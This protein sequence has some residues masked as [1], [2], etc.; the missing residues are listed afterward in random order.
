MIG[1][2]ENRQRDGGNEVR[3]QGGGGGGCAERESRGSLSSCSHF[4]GSVFNYLE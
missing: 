2:G 3:T 4:N 1:E